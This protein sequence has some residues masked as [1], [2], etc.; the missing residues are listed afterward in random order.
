MCSP[1]LPLCVVLIKELPHPRLQLLAE[2]FHLSNLIHDDKARP[3]QH[4]LAQTAQG[5]LLKLCHI[6]R[7]LANFWSGLVGRLKSPGDSERR[8]IKTF[9]SVCGGT[10]EGP[11]GL[12]HCGHVITEVHPSNPLSIIVVIVPMIRLLIQ[13]VFFKMCSPKSSK[14]FSVSK[15]FQTFELV[16]P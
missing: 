6:D 3:L 5:N 11:T 8:E 7:V 13:G 9:E 14:C 15:M 1:H 2:A 10:V 16:P 12:Y 4:I